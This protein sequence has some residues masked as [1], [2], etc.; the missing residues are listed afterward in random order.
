M[1]GSAVRADSTAI[2]SEDSKASM[3]TCQG[4]DRHGLKHL[5]A[6][7]AEDTY[8]GGSYTVVGMKFGPR[9]V[10]GI[11]PAHSIVLNERWGWAYE[12]V[13]ARRNE[14][15]KGLAVFYGLLSL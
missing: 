11:K 8:R 14:F 1:D 9:H 3:A 4:V 6:L 5:F 2:S 13:I 12:P 15:Q 7:V 10:S